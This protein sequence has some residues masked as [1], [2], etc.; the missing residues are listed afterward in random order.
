[1]EATERTLAASDVVRVYARVAPLYDLWAAATEARARA[2]ALD[3][4]ALRDG[5]SVLEVAV[6]TGVLFAEILRRNPSGVT[7]GVDLTDAMLAKARQ[8]AAALG[9][10]RWRLRVGDAQH[11]D[12]ADA[13]FDLLV[14]TYMLDLLPEAE[15]PR[16]LGEFH[17]VLRPGGRLL[18]VN[19]APTETWLYR[20]WM[21]LYRVNPAWLGG[22]RGVL[23]DGPVVR[24]G[25]RVVA[26]ELVVQFRVPSSVVLAVKP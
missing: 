5:E 8:K 13:S 2:R 25:F 24:A 20:A 18:L 12:F 9:A 15:F 23:V 26:S 21:W 6:G 10:G 11:L 14:N 4:A 7:E 17:R 1:M 19:L 22:C 3:L 16:V